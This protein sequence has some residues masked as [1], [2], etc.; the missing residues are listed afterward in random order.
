MNKAVLEATEKCS[1]SELL[2]LLFKQEIIHFVKVVVS[3][4]EDGDKIVTC[5]MFTSWKNA[6]KEIEKY[7]NTH[8]VSVWLC[9]N[10]ADVNI[11]DVEVANHITQDK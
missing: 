10:N 5:K 8:Y 9:V 1:K 7:K 4:D 2:N 6:I 11:L 3:L